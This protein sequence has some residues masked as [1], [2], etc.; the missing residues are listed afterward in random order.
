MVFVL[1]EESAIG[2]ILIGNV[3]PRG[4]LC[5]NFRTKALYS[6]QVLEFLIVTELIA[7][8]KNHPI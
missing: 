7:D 6:S 1:L 8:I 5:V 3:S 2:E 4:F